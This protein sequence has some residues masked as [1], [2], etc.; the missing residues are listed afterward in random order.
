MASV[1]LRA[2]ATRLVPSLSLVITEVVLG[3][4]MVYRS[5]KP[6]IGHRARASKHILLRLRGAQ[7]AS[8]G[9]VYATNRE[10][11][12]LRV[13]QGRPGVQVHLFF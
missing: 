2:L 4:T 10:V 12:S 9:L 7:M 11:C 13:A 6:I 3:H 1:L 5:R 8:T